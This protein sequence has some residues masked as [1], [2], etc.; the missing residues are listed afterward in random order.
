MDSTVGSSLFFRPRLC[1][2]RYE[3]GWEGYKTLVLGVFFVCEREDCPFRDECLR[4][5]AQIDEKCP[6]YAGMDASYYLLSNSAQIEV[7]SFLE[8]SA[9]YPTYSSITKYLFQTNL[10]VP[11][12]QKEALWDS[13]AFANFLQNYQACFDTLDYARDAALLDASM[14]AFLQLLELLSPE[15]LFVF[16]TAVA[17][18]LRAHNIPG[19][20]YV[21]YDDGWTLPVHR[22]LY[23]VI[24]KMAPAD[25][26]AS[27]SKGRASRFNHSQAVLR[28]IIRLRKPTKN[29][30]GNYLTRYV[31]PHIWDKD[32]EQ[33]LYV[34]SLHFALSPKQKKALHQFLVSLY[35]RGFIQMD[36]SLVFS[37]NSPVK[38]AQY[39]KDGLIVELY[40]WLAKIEG[41]D[42]LDIPEWIF[43]Q[44]LGIPC[45]SDSE[46]RTIRKKEYAKH[47][48]ASA[49]P[50]RLRG[51]F[52][53]LFR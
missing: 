19:L 16:D 10:H 53:E 46:W 7:D 14:P 4:N 1:R 9:R 50:S 24:P 34:E 31:R 37:E 6:A 44:A 45:K 13:I 20:E 12:G 51:L 11:D 41:Q 39:E 38:L 36:H 33:Y 5:T 2:E 22:F 15:L 3:R 47:C 52:P 30:K 17:D 48:D 26:L 21:D 18:C 40:K 28:E 49:A 42:K 23:K 29:L 25:I 43:A 35:Q 27:I 32:F 8:G